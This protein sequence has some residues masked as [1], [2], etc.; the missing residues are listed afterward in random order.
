MNWWE[1]YLHENCVIG[2]IY[3]FYISIT[4]Y[5]VTYSQYYTMKS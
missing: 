5:F 4:V 3:P 2:V 1:L